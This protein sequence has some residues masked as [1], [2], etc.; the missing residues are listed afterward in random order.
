MKTHFLVLLFAV[1]LALPAACTAGKAANRSQFHPPQT[2]AEKALDHIL[3]MDRDDRYLYD[4]IFKLPNRAKN[5]DKDYSRFF[6]K[7][8]QAIW[9]K[10]Y[11]SIPE[12]S[13]GG[14]YVDSSFITCG[15]DAPDQNLYMTVKSDGHEAYIDTTWPELAKDTK[16]PSTPYYKMIK[17]DGLWKLD[18]TGCGEELRFNAK[19]TFHS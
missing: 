6:T 11:L 18:G 5:W 4:F 14:R 7:R 1:L 16:L 10:K 15:Q 9:E 12:E 2:E 19:Q 8:L 13:E 17:E 3:I